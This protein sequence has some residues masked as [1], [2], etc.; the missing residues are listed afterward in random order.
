VTTKIVLGEKSGYDAAIERTRRMVKELGVDYIDLVL[1]H[2]P[3]VISAR[4]MSKF[5]YT[6]YIAKGDVSSKI[7]S[8]EEVKKIR[9]DTWR[10]LSKL[11]DDGLIR[12]AGVS[13]FNIDYMK[14]IQDLNLAP[15]AAN[16]MQY[17]PWKP[18]WMEKIVQYCHQQKIAV[19][20]YFSLGGHDHK[21]K[22][23][24]V[25]TLGSIAKAHGK[26]PAQILLRWSLQKNV[27]IIPGT[28]NHKHMADNLATYGF[29][30][31]DADM[32]KLDGMSSLPISENFMFFDF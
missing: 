30:L 5:L 14:Q 29:S 15:I 20:G 18:D 9:L 2:A 11:K 7:G 22:V 8:D 28:G 17:H 27:S 23:K 21:D 10:G 32:I 25:E 13:N 19:T 26:R 1:I 12:N 6:K 4:M 31:S 24:D 3:V 16:Q